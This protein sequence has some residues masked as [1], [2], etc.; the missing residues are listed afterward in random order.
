ME[1]EEQSIK[2]LHTGHQIDML[3]GSLLDKILLFALPLAASSILQQLFNSADVAV[4]GRFAGNTAQAAVGSSSPLI[5]LFINF[6]T[7]LSIGTNAVIARQIG[8]GENDKI[9]KSVHTSVAL[10]LVSGLAMAFLGIIITRPALNLMG[11]P[12]DVIEQAVLYLRIYFGGMPFILIYNFG[13]AVL[14]SKGDSRRPMYSLFSAGILNVLLNLLLVIVFHLGVAGVAIATVISNAMSAA[15]VIWFLMTEEPLFRFKLQSL[16]LDK[17]SLS[18]IL[19]VGVPAGIQSMVFS[20]SNVCI[21]SAINSFGTI[22]MAGSTDAWYF[23]AFAYFMVSAFAQTAVTFTSQNFGAGNQERCKKIFNMCMA[24]SLLFSGILVTLFEF[25]QHFFIRLYTTDEA[26]ISAA[27]IRMSH[28]LI[29]EWMPSTYE[30][31]GSA[32]R[33]MGHSVLPAMIT[34]LGTCV[35]RILWVFTVFA[36]FHDFGVLMTAYPVSWVLTGS[37][38]IAAYYIIRRKLFRVSPL[39]A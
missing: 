18:S 6:F 13:S 24:S 23:E 14:R 37:V 29:L 25:G 31:S 21:Q 10:A 9:Q 26:V 38:M 7:G 12:S 35:F 11:T 39:K 27:L 1:Q 17:T 15:L 8:Q 19:M 20:L 2:P 36:R 4:V 33:G 16:C 32:L 3:H 28:V 22:T 34:I 5:N 30:I